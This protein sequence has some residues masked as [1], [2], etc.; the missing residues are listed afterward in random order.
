MADSSENLGLPEGTIIAIEDKDELIDAVMRELLGQGLHCVA[1]HG[2]FHLVL[3]SNSALELV[4]ARMMYDPDLRAM[5]WQDTHVWLLDHEGDELVY[6]TII[7]H[8]GIPEEHVHRCCVETLVQEDP[9]V[10]LDCCMVE[11]DDVQS[12]GSGT[13][14]RCSVLLVLAQD[15]DKLAGIHLWSQQVEVYW[16]TK[17]IDL[18]LES[19]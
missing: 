19:P 4:Y 10:R 11:L 16:F 17:T 12:L 1:N 6:E 8:S 15:R 14:D 13:C 3:S 5:P 9:T 2:T 18:H 7:S